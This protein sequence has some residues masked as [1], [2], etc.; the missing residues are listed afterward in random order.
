MP[1]V[2]Q[3]Y[4]KN[5]SSSSS[6]SSSWSMTDRIFCHFG[7]FFCHFT[8][9]TT[10]KTKIFK[11]WKKAWIY[12]Y[13]THVHL[14]CKSNDVWFLR[15]R[16]RQTEFF[17]IL[18]HFLLIYPLKTWKIKILKK[19]KKAME[20]SFFTSVPKI[21]IICYRGVWGPALKALDG[22]WAKHQKIF[23]I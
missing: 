15:Y 23:R 3:P 17:V 5:N 20:I 21:M 22:V 2:G 14:K 7:L 11:N 9:L 16:V 6:S 12:Y 1:F 19:W 8:P 4:H 10:R 13:F 18:D